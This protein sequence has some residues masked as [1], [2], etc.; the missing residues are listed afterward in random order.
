MLSAGWTGRLVTFAA[1]VGVVAVLTAAGCSGDDD[2]E[3]SAPASTPATTATTANASETRD[4]PTRTGPTPAVQD[5]HIPVDPIETIPM[6]VQMIADT[7]ASVTRFDI[8]WADVAP[9]RPE[10]PT[11][12]NDPA[13]DFSRYDMVMTGLADNGITP[14]VSV[15]NTPDWAANGL[16]VEGPINPGAPDP[17][18]FAAFMEAVATR[19]SGEFVGPDGNVLPE[20]RHLEIW[21]EPNLSAY[22]A[23]QSED[24]VQVSLDNYAGL[25]KAAFPAIVRANPDAMVIAG[26]GGPRGLTT[27]TGTGALDWL[28][29]LQQRDIPLHAYS[30]HI[31]PLAA[32][33]M[34]TQ[35]FP[36]WSS[37][38]LLL[39]ELDRFEPGLPLFITEAGYTTSVTEYRDEAAT[40]TED[41]QAQYLTQIFELPQ[42]NNPRLQSVVWFNLQD[43]SGWPAG[44]LRED[45]S[46]K[47]SL[48]SFQRV[49]QS[50]PKGLD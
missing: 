11:D 27:E 20:A 36:S 9:T 6:R 33:T 41:E 32:P 48:S 31:Y 50:G 35:A 49:A 14:I 47:P 21:N 17:A 7:G 1:L 16:T 25:V 8:F 22:F 10:N 29:G 2:G 19:Y 18:V 34:P 46:P 45:L 44:L 23:P 5:D 28:R 38:D 4:A 43:N 26:V 15:Y 13:Y 12:P 30:Q 37:I 42:V 3:S 40:V 39:E 24:G